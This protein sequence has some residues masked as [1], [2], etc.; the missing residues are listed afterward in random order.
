MVLPLPSPAPEVWGV[1]ENNEEHAGVLRRGREI[2]SVGSADATALGVGTAGG[3]GSYESTIYDETGPHA[4]SAALVHSGS[5]PVSQAMELDMGERT[6]I[7]RPHSLCQ[8]VQDTSR[9]LTSGICIR[10]DLDNMLRPCFPIAPSNARIP[11][12]PTIS[13]SCGSGGM[14]PAIRMSEEL[15]E[16]V[17]RCDIGTV[18]ELLASRM[19][20]NE[21]TA[22]GSYILF[23]AVIKARDS[24]ILHLLLSH[25]ANVRSADERGNQVMHLWARATVGHNAL[26]EIGKSLL[27]AAADPNAQ[28]YDDGMSPLH[29]VSIGHNNR[30]GWLDFHKALLLVR[31]D[32]NICILTSIGQF[33]YSLISPD[34]RV[35]TK[36]AHTVSDKRYSSCCGSWQL[37]KM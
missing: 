25:N 13:P 17:S 34:G 18:K 20:V 5:K 15:F 26:L 2:F 32:A 36:Q 19:D 16:A 6:E 24:E 12:A 14:L 22:R 31:N 23:R 35:A 3:T 11:Q 10:N 28:R 21:R 4:P 27:S 1:S 37:A 9:S 33:P 7:V 30:R 8:E 29:H